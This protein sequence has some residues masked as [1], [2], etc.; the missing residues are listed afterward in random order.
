MQNIASSISAKIIFAHMTDS[1]FDSS[2][3]LN[4]KNYKLSFY[5]Y[6]KEKVFGNLDE[7]NRFF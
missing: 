2:D 1:P 5:N 7:K 3:L 4:N 6:E